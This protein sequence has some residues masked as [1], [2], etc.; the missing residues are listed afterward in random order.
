M[1]LSTADVA[2]QKDCT[3]M[4]VRNAIQRGELNAL[5]VGRSW[6]VADDNALASWSVQETG[7]RLH[8]Q[9]VEA[10]GGGN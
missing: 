7:G 3:R 9:L 1:F 8:R 2:T 5:R 4:A 10:G 6:V